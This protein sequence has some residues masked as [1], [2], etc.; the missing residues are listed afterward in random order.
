MYND[1]FTVGPFTVHGYGLMIALGILGAY[2]LTD[3]RKKDLFSSELL[4]DMFFWV[5]IAAFIGAKVL[6]WLTILPDII[7]QPSILLNIGGGFVVYGSI[8]G[9][10]FVLV[11][12]A[13]KHHI[14]LLDL[15]DLLMPSAAFAQGFGRIGC[16]LAGC[17]YGIKYDGPFA[18]TFTNSA[19]APNNVSLFP[20]Q[21]LSSLLNF[22]NCFIL[23]YISK[24]CKKPGVVTAC[25]L[26]FYS[27][28][29][30]CIEF[31]RGDL[32]RG[33]VGALSTSQFISVFIFLGGIALLVHCLKKKE[34]A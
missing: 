22:L 30:F 26:I 18:I 8:I 2:W 11:F 21:L 1:L 34:N 12:Y 4:A 13:S 29:R 6:Y 24:K 31:V 17:C 28:G 16:F 27:L 14:K 9:G 19:Y 32:E 25:Y 20:S 3:L 10:L 15:L 7:A 23:I 5:I 33:F